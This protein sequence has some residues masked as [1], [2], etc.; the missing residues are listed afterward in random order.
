MNH[1]NHEKSYFLEAGKVIITGEPCQIVT[2]LGSC[3]S[4]TMYH[5]G[6][7]IAA[8]C[9]AL[10]PQCDK[11]KIT[12]SLNENEIFKYVDCSIKKMIEMFERE[13]IDTAEIEVKVFGGGEIL[14]NSSESK[15]LTVG[16]QNIESALT[17]LEEKHLKI[18]NSDVGG[19]LGRK[20]IFHTDNGEVYLKKIK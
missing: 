2:V 10:Y 11:N 7:K 9:H 19:K 3:I 4:V 5:P 1:R 18:K 13:S 17:I 12:S 15:L 8:M 20:I 6:R 14:N 16:K